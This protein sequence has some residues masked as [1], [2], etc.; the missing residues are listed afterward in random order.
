MNAL[1][2]LL[3]KLSNEQPLN[4][5]DIVAGMLLAT[6]IIS[7]CHLLT[8]LATRWGDRHIAV[9]SLAASM[10]IHGVCLL[11]LEVFEPLTTARTEGSEFRAETPDVVTQIVVE[12]DQNVLL[13]D[14]GN[15]AVADR[16]LQPDIQLFRFETPAPEITRSELPEPELRLDRLES[17]NTKVED[18]N[19]FEERQMTELSVAADSAVQGPRQAAVEDPFADLNTQFDRN[20]ADV[21]ALQQLRTLPRQ[22]SSEQQPRADIMPQ[23]AVASATDLNLLPTPE[24]VA[25]N[26][27]TQS[28]NSVVLPQATMND[29]EQIQRQLAPDVSAESLSNT[30]LAMNAP[31]PKPGPAT[32]FQPRLPRPARAAPDRTPAPTPTRDNPQIPRTPL[33]LTTNYEDVRIGLMA[34]EYSESISSAAALVET[35]LPTIRRRDNPPQSYQLRNVQQRRNTAQRFGGTQESE[36]AVEASLRWLA[37]VQQSDGR[38]DAS[39][40]GSGQVKLDE[41][42]VD[43]NFAGREADTGVTALVILSFLGAGYTHEQGTHAIAVDRALDWLIQQQTSDGNLS[44]NAEHFARMY[45]H[46]MATYALAEAYGMQKQTLLGPIVDPQLMAQPRLIANRTFTILRQKLLPQPVLLSIADESAQFLLNERLI[47][48]MRKVDDLRLR[49]AL[50]R[51]VTYT[52]G[53]QDPRGGGWRYK[54]GQEGDV[55]MFGWQMMSLRSAEIAGVTLDPRVRLR[56]NDFLNSVRQGESGGL[57]GYRRN[58]RINGRDSE[59]VTP[60][61]TAEA[62]FCQQMLGYP[63]DTAAS[64]ESIGYLLRH[65]PRLAE[66]NYYYLYYGTLAMYQYGGKPWDEWNS[67]VRD[68]LISQQRTDGALAGSWDPNDPWGRYGGRLYSTALAT[69]TLEVYYRLLPLYRMNESSPRTD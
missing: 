37:S 66:L 57:F 40:H 22:G 5:D 32:S 3:R 65:M 19:Q 16:I 39:D 61:M 17:L 24:D 50:A 60:V 27:T 55:S 11:G 56:M 47:Y 23:Q 13:R 53:Q 30:G 1:S 64:R 54:F 58:T 2:Q 7:A 62:L 42:G 35:D 29:A 12:S 46:A 51:A 25:M 41:N 52:I 33:P 48:S 63:R 8:M 67:V 10:L 28:D 36:A 45:C 20:A 44:G 9:K 38:W 6:M 34:P 49:S 31:E 15:N 18:V 59:P 21:P 4:G 43:R 68:T 14:S 26:L 69:L